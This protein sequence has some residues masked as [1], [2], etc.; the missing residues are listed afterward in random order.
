MNTYDS[1]MLDSDAPVDVWAEN[2]LRDQ[3]LALIEDDQAHVVS[4][5]QG[6]PVRSYIR[7]ST[8]KAWRDALYTAQEAVIAVI[9]IELNPQVDTLTVRLAGTMASQAATGLALNFALYLGLNPET[10]DDVQIPYATGLTGVELTVSNPRTQD[11]YQ[12][13][14][15]V[16][17]SCELPA[18]PGAAAWQVMV[19]A[20]ALEDGTWGGTGSPSSATSGADNVVYFEDEQE[21]FELGNF[22]SPDER[23]RLYGGRLIYSQGAAICALTGWRA[24]SIALDITGVDGSSIVPAQPE[25]YANIPVQGHVHARH[26]FVINRARDHRRY[27]SIRPSGDLLVGVETT[28]RSPWRRADFGT[29]VLLRD[30]IY[31]DRGARGVLSARVAA[32]YYTGDNVSN[33]NADAASPDRE[34]SQQ[35]T[36]RLLQWEDGETSPTLITSATVTLELRGWT[37]RNN[38]TQHRALND[39]SRWRFQGT[40]ARLEEFTSRDSGSGYRWGTLAPFEVALLNLLR[41]DL[42]L[43]GLT[44]DADL[45]LILEVIVPVE[46]SPPAYNPSKGNN[47]TLTG[48]NWTL[49]YHSSVVAVGG[50]ICWEGP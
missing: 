37:G 39:V 31:L 30:S 48:S 5:M 8:A 43:D 16:T 28:Q 44:F 49:P 38:T 46:G 20:Y 12:D 22:D 50:S 47:P 23:G 26:D 2:A 42:A 19:G 21:W 10:R 34:S 13:Y 24:R 1:E 11:T 41:F 32:L 6:N 15:I 4:P 14:L 18:D 40:H 17:M 45:P 27:L 25:L 9:P 35:F 36:V 29:R 3:H 33:D 7:A